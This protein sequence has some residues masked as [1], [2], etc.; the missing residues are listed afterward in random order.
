[1]IDSHCHLA[2]EVFAADLN[3][4]IDR[5]RA[6]GLTH[7]LCILAAGNT[8]EA[9][10]AAGRGHAV[11]RRADVGGRSPPPGRRICRAGTG[12]CRRGE[13]TTRRGPAS[14][15]RRRDRTRLPLRLRAAAHA[16][17]GLSRA[18]AAG[19]RAR[20]ADHD[21]HP[22]SR[23]RHAR[24]PAGR[25]RGVSAG[26]AA[27]LHRHAAAGRRGAR[28]GTAHFICRHRHVPQGPRTARPSR[29][30]VPADRLL[31]ETDSPYLAPTP[32][33]GKRN[34]PAWVAR[35]VEELALL[36]GLS[37]P[38]AAATRS[39]RISRRFFGRKPRVGRS[40]FVDTLCGSM[41]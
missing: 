19:T 11:A 27:L 25:E 35:V 12:R 18:G 10:R 1:M 2:D 17:A 24:H 13:D 3:A 26:R 5:A 30:L 36:R 34:E 29:P 33:R 9:S 16:T 20:S 15:R 23:R 8:A 32:Y 39:R 37:T 40:P 28:A 21:S 14:P 31:C 4:V 7:A 6:A 38:R 41:V 22:G